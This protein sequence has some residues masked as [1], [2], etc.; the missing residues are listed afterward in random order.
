MDF[1]IGINEY[2][3]SKSGY[4]L[5][6]NNKLVRDKILNMEEV[7]KEIKK[8]LRLRFKENIK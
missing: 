3:L 5:F 4:S 7:L 8:Y 1:E 6:I 2:P